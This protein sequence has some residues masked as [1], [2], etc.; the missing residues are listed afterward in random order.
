VRILS[1]VPSLD[2]SVCSIETRRFEQESDRLGPELAVLTVSMD[3]P[4]AQKRWAE[5]TGIKRIHLLSDY[6]YR[7]FGEKYGVLIKELG[8]LARVVFVVDQTDTIRHIQIVPEVTNE[9][10]YD[11]ALDAARQAAGALK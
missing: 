9:P 10:D 3:L 4:F 11:A 1:S 6:K 7:T 2:T 8:L 5:E